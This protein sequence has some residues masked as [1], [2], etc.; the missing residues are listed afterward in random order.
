MGLKSRRGSADDD[1]DDDCEIIM[2]VSA[3][4]TSPTKHF[5]D[6]DALQSALQTGNLASAQHAFAAF[7]QHV[8]QA[9][10]VGG[11][12]L[13]TAGSQSG[14]DLQRLGSALKAADLNGA[15]SAL[16]SLKQD[17]QLVENS[18]TAA[19]MMPHKKA[20]HATA[21]VG[22]ILNLRG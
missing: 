2:N 13:F 17:V 1:N 11:S 5:A 20:A 16:A 14:K 10:T 22:S 15:Q 19:Q 3:I 7:E 12:S 18:P 8:Q 9:Q 6:F 4:S 21:S